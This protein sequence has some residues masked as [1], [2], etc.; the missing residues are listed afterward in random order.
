MSRKELVTLT[1]MCLIEDS[2]G[3]VVVQRRDPKLYRWSGLAFPGGHV[4][5]G[6][7]FHDAVVREVQEET[8]LSIECPRLVGLKHWPDKDGHRYLVFLYKATS[9]SGQLQSS[10]EGEVFWC[11]KTDL[12]QMELAY[13][14]LEVL[15]VMDDP[16]LSEFFYTHKGLNGEWDKNFR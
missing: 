5:F 6:E 2:K 16:I 9:F 15:K 1:N 10:E 13:D 4:E 11:P 8:G 7:N 12:P 3:N 14:L